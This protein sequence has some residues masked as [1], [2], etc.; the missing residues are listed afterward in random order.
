MGRGAAET[1]DWPLDGHSRRRRTHYWTNQPPRAAASSPG[2]RQLLTVWVHAGGA[3]GTGH[4]S[5]GS[6]SG[7]PHRRQTKAA[8]RRSN[9]PVYH[10][11]AA[12]AAGAGRGG[13]RRCY[14]T[15]VRTCPGKSR[16]RRCGRLEIA[17]VNAGHGSQRQKP[18]NAGRP[19]LFE[20][21][22][23]STDERSRRVIELRRPTTDTPQSAAAATARCPPPVA[24]SHD[25]W[26]QHVTP[27]NSAT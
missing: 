26:Q 2:S 5:R 10:R 11:A 24:G 1:A 8:C 18:D 27:L 15:A 22:I 9:C 17:G 13:F 25:T 7:T 6:R 3:R 21:P 12:A 19:V 4:R 23:H 20:Y 16:P 14:G